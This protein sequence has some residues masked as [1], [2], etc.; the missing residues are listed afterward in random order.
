VGASIK[1]LKDWKV[2]DEFLSTLQ[3]ETET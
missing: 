2:D 1:V 3:E